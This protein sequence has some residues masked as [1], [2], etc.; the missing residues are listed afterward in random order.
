MAH[1]ERIFNEAQ[2]QGVK[3]QINENKLLFA[4]WLAGKRNYNGQVSC[5][6][7]ESITK[8]IQKKKEKKIKEEIPK[9]KI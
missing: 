6:A 3:A 1:A 9:G 8:I 7:L 2:R 4:K 5:Q